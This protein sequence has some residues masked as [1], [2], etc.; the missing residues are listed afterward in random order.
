MLGVVVMASCLRSD[1]QQP[2]VAAVSACVE[3]TGIGAFADGG[4][5]AES[6]GTSPALVRIFLRN[7]LGDAFRM[8]HAQV[9]L[10]GLVRF[11]QEDAALEASRSERGLPV[12][13]CPLSPGDHKVQLL[14]QLQGNGSGASSYLKGFHFDVRSGH[15]FTKLA[16]RQVS[17]E[18]VAYEKSGS[19]APPEE[20]PKIRFVQVGA[21]Q[22]PPRVPTSTEPAKPGTTARDLCPAVDHAAAVS[23]AGMGAD[24]SPALARIFLRNELGDAFSLNHVSVVLDGVVKLDARPGASVAE[25]YR[26]GVPVFVAPLAPGDHTLQ[27]QLRLKGSGSGVSSYLQ[28]Y[29]FD[30]KSAHA[31][32]KS[33]DRPV[34]LEI[35]GY[36]K[37]GPK[38]ALEE[39]PALRFVQIGAPEGPEHHAEPPPRDAGDAGPYGL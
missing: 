24:A 38:V 6:A 36:E 13:V 8:K 11:D 22:T 3:L 21:A 28:G 14:I 5:P 7:E 32:A 35:V 30:L 12:F 33:A 27:V 37:G 9:V 18:I 26:Q 25:R 20:R 17:L 39:R 1:R 2:A 19:Q 4:S 29:H 23:D 16:E 10:D 31:F 15:S 34:C